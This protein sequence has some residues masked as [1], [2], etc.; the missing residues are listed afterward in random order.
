[1][2]TEMGYVATGEPILRPVSGHFLISSPTPKS[3]PDLRQTRP[4]GLP[5]TLFFVFFNFGLNQPKHPGLFHETIIPE[6]FMWHCEQQVQSVGKVRIT[7][8]S[9]KSRSMAMQMVSGVKGHVKT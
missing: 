6:H 5:E 4:L 9:G 2:R 1:M 7:N 8:L 3:K